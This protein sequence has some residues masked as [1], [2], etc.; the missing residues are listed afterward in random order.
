MII[1]RRVLL[2]AL[3]LAG[4]STIARTRVDA[5]AMSGTQAGAVPEPLLRGGDARAAKLHD[6]TPRH[7]SRDVG[8]VLRQQDERVSSLSS[9]TTSPTPIFTATPKPVPFTFRRLGY[10]PREAPRKYLPYNRSSPVS[11]TDTGV[12]DATGVRM[13]AIGSKLY[14]HPVAQAQWG[15]D[16]LSSY[17]LTRDSFYLNRAVLQAQRLVDSHVVSREAWYFPYPFDFLLHGYSDELMQAPWYSAMA[18]GLALSL[19]SRL[20]GET[21][22]QLWRDSADGTFASFLNPPQQGLP[23]TVQL[24]GYGY[25]WLEEYARWPP[26]DSDFTF[27]G[28]VFALFGLY[29]YA[30]LT[31]DARA[32]LL[33]DGALTT[34]RQYSQVGIRAPRWASRYC[35]AHVVND[36]GYHHIHI[37]QLLACSAMTADSVFARIA[38]QL[39][40][41]YPPPQVSGSVSFAAGYHKGYRFDRYG[42]VTS[43][44][45]L[46]LSRASSAPGDRRIRIRNWGIFYR[47]SAGFLA[48]YFV[49]EAYP[50][51][52]LMGLHVGLAYF[53][54]RRAV[55]G[56]Q[57]Y[58]GYQ[59]T[60]DGRVV[61]SRST[62]FSAPSSAPFDSSGVIN[63]RPHVHITAGVFA[64][65]WVPTQNLVLQ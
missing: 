18:Q 22:N 31:G 12:H 48:G 37:T 7:P 50:V 20:Y 41:D 13:L 54:E 59:F 14:N 34:A 1:D 35:L 23:W 60:S 4:L 39:R 16:N 30:V 33:W 55:F 45:A 2:R 5:L 6:G 26:P 21:R 57:T 63:G 27:N 64:G 38:D 61:G 11:K 58:S 46:N 3:A 44:L 28:L 8:R 10:T 52:R 9:A 49:G 15:L 40:D 19:F 24:D 25:L 32:V 36:P 53:P 29:D 65:F 47:I 62:G 17:Q 43:S 51:R 42:R 56:A